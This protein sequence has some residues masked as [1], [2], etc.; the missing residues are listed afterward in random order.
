M[1]A[2]KIV[3]L[4][5]F[6][7]DVQSVTRGIAEPDFEIRFAATAEPA[8]HCA[9]VADADF[10]LVGPA[11]V[12]AELLAHC[13]RVR[14]VQKYGVGIE[15][16]DLD[17]ARRAG[18]GVAIAAAGNA[19]PVSELALGLMIAVNRRMITGDQSTRSG[20]WMKNEMRST[21][22]QLDGKTVGLLGFGHIARM[23]ARRLAGFD[24]EILYHSRRR[25][26]AETEHFL[27]ARFVPFDD[28]LM[29]SDILS[30]HVPLTRETHHLID[31]TA[32]AKMKPGAI[33]VNTAR[34][35]IVD[36]EALFEA[37]SASRLRGAGLDVF[38]VEPPQAYNPLFGLENVVLMPHAGGAVF[39]NVPIVM[40]HAIDN[41]RRVLAGQ[42][43]PAEDVIVPPRC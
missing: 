42:S 19:A 41:M 36:E 38:A 31:E 20:R 26:D 12:T 15:K 13:A 11:P 4:D 39:D 8:E 1:T 9:L 14:L 22:L 35:A 5:V 28:L 23:T 25:A 33:L 3:C 17:A 30:L 29:R 10:L 24:V 34:G 27:R 16:V 37:L 40:G 21:A 43:L 2:P 18:I 32:M 7:P 6:A